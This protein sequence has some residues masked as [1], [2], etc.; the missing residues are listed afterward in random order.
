MVKTD[1][2]FFTADAVPIVLQY[3]MDH[4]I[5]IDSHRSVPFND[6]RNNEALC[7]K[8]CVILKIKY[9]A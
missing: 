2:H 1:L 3:L 7:P 8:N 6:V 9:D 4:G 5:K